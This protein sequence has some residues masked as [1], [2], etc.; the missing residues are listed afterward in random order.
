MGAGV[1]QV[2]RTVVAPPAVTV[3]ATSLTPAVVGAPEIVPVAGSM[4][5]P[6]GSPVAAKAA[7][8]PAGACATIW[9]VT[10]SPMFVAWRPGF[11]T[12]GV[13]SA[14]VQSNVAVL[15]F[16]PGSVTVTVTF[17][18]PVAVGCPVIW[19]LFG[20]RARPAGS[21]AAAYWSTSPGVTGVATTCSETVAPVV[22]LWSPGLSTTGTVG[23][24]TTQANLAVA[25][26]VPSVTVTVTSVKPAAVGVPVMRPVFASMASP[27]GRP[28]AAYV[29]VPGG[30]DCD[31]AWICRLTGVPTAV[32]CRPGEVTVGTG[33]KT[34][35]S[36]ATVVVWVP[37]ETVDRHVGDDP[38]WSACR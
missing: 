6:A 5:R 38:P 26:A 7:V 9:R 11:V 37:S 33:S 29:S 32:D 3:T 24:S 36:N 27:A 8:V 2:N 13:G 23:G 28:G 19:P 4:A 31:C 15:A 21:P 35:Q 30:T 22:E 12:V 1:T 17:D 18:V 20:S 34:S 14:T 25:A 10:A 16:V